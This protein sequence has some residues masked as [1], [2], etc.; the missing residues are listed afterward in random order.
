MQITNDIMPESFAE[1][2][3]F[4]SSHACQSSPCA[5]TAAEVTKH[6]LKNI[7][8]TFLQNYLEAMT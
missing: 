1:P 8:D 6:Y 4:T 3:G 7:M 5:A 2:G